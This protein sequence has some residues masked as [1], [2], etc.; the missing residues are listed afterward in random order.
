MSFSSMV[1]RLL[2]V[3]F[4]LILSYYS[5]DRPAAVETDKKADSGWRSGEE[6]GT[7]DNE[8]VVPLPPFDEADVISFV[9]EDAFRYSESE[10]SDS[11]YAVGVGSVEYEVICTVYIF[12]SA[13]N[14]CSI[15]SDLYL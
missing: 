9:P 7:Q 8:P 12:S 4:G 14:L 10:F 1:F 13:C 6:A 2:I 5:N 3:F 15:A 11:A